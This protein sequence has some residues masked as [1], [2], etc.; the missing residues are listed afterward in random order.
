MVEQYMKLLSAEEVLQNNI[1]KL[2]D[3]FCLYYGEDSRSFIE[4]KFSNFLFIPY[5]TPDNLNALLI[6][7]IKKNL[8][9]FF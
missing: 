7:L 6:K 2:I 9:N 1:S 3:I 5:Q 8:R 4:E